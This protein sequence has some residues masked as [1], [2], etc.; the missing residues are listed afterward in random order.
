M[1]NSNIKIQV[2]GDYEKVNA[3][4]TE[5]IKSRAELRVASDKAF[6]NAVTVGW[7]LGAA[8]ERANSLEIVDALINGLIETEVDARM[9]LDILRKMLVESNPNTEGEKN[10]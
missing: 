7:E 2:T 5:A 4:T 3:A 6:D 9:T 8:D 1:E 10:E